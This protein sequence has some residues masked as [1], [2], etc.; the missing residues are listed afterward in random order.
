[1]QEQDTEYPV[2]YLRIQV[3]R[4][5]PT[6]Y[7]KILVLGYYT[8]APG[9]PWIWSAPGDT[10]VS[11][12][13]RHKFDCDQGNGPYGFQKEEIERKNRFVRTALHY[14]SGGSTPDGRK[15]L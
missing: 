7:S 14:D 10:L 8:F 4:F 9:C 11:N 13:S 6:L 5:Y 15:V 12:Y 3:T 2:L 1:M